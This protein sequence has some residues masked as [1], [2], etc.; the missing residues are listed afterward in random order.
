MENLPGLS[1][2]F[3]A[4][5]CFPSFPRIMISMELLWFGARL[6]EGMAFQF[7]SSIRL[8]STYSMRGRTRSAEKIGAALQG[9]CVVY[10]WFSQGLVACLWAAMQPSRNLSLLPC[11]VGFPL[12]LC[13]SGFHS[14]SPTESGFVRVP[15][16]AREGKPQH[17]EFFKPPLSSCCCCA[18]GQS[19]SHSQSQSHCGRRQHE[20]IDTER[21]TVVGVF[22]K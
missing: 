13:H 3:Y 19:E 6:E 10:R 12:V 20:S 5:S 1:W 21:W 8:L 22:S 16:T 7:M 15:R 4:F 14:F 18:T 9:G 11:K 17:K 2:S